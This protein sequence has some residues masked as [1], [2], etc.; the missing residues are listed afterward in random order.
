MWL[1][2]VLAAGLAENEDRDVGWW[3]HVKRLAAR[4]EA[5]PSDA[6]VAL[7]LASGFAQ[8]RYLEQAIE[9]ADVARQRGA[10]PN[11]VHLVVGRAH[12]RSA[13]WE[14]AVR[15][16][17]E[18]VLAAPENTHAHIML[19]E[20]LTAAPPGAIGLTVDRDRLTRALR[21]KGY[22]TP[23]SRPRAPRPAAAA[24][25]TRR[26]FQSLRNGRFPEAAGRFEAALAQDPRH[27]D[28]FRGLGTA[29]AR[30]ERLVQAR[31]AYALF[32]HLAPRETRDVRVVRRLLVDADRRRGLGGDGTP[33]P[34]PTR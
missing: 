22:Y 3:S 19:W 30:M 34:L 27:A 31:G 21:Q 9:W 33:R 5:R 11:R 4:A 24:D 13:R 23:P 15:A 32:L 7:R 6:E 8:R 1:L 14:G 28:A 18:V 10:D 26:G 29:Y 20:A 25:Q 12:L 2:I 17:Y 16:Y